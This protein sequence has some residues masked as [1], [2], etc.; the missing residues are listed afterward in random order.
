MWLNNIYRPQGKV[1]FSGEC[2][3]QSVHNQ[4]HG[5]WFTAHPSGS[6]TARSVRIILECF[7]VST[8]FSLNCKVSVNDILQA[9]HRN[10]FD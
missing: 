4:P 3:S 7:L 9:G 2:V 6:V 1:M 8:L 5:Y 10:V